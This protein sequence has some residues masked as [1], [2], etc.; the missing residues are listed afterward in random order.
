MTPQ[1]VLVR[2]LMRGLYPLLLVASWA[3]L[4]RGHDAP[5]GGFIA[6]VIAAAATAALALTFDNAHARRL[7]PLDPVR[8]AMT[9]VLMALAAGLPA[10]YAGLPFLTHMD[11]PGLLP[12]TVLVFDVGVYLCVWGALGGY[13]LALL[14][15]GPAP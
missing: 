11:L 7:M 6:G 1:S 2:V 10:L 5:G 4:V 12:S 15:T 14:D 3:V 13:G 9:G 8:L